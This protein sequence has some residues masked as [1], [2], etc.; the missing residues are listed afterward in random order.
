[1][2]TQMTQKLTDEFF[3]HNQK[4]KTVDNILNLQVLK[5]EQDDKDRMKK[6][7]QSSKIQIEE[8]KLSRP[9]VTKL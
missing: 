7:S 9:E 6:V 1:M 8:K 2:V 5:D 4:I 3:L